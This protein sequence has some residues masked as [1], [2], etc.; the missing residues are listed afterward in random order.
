M[1]TSFLLSGLSCIAVSIIPMRSDDGERTSEW[2]FSL[3]FGEQI[4][5]KLAKYF[6]K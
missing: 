2:L 1:L 4:D 6:T 5:V 3:H